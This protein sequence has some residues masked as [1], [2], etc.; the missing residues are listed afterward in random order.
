MAWVNEKFILSA[1][2]TQADKGNTNNSPDIHYYSSYG[3]NG[4]YQ[5]CNDYSLSAGSGWKNPYNEDSPDNS[6]DKVDHGNTWSVGFIWEN[7][8]LEGDNVGFAIGTAHTHRDDSDYDDLL[9]W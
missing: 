4:S 6:K 5:Y 1:A 3:I 9:A 8:F 7:A 2:Y